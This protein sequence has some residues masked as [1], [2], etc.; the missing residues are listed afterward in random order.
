MLTIW[1][2][3]GMNSLPSLRGRDVLPKTVF[4]QRQD[5]AMAKKKATRKKSNGNRTNL[6]FEAKLEK[7]T[8]H[9]ILGTL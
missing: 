5:L 4:V 6:G 1:P 9:R 7:A 2:A 8:M 3:W